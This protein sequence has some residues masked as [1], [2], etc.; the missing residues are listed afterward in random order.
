M[1]LT[2]NK[3]VLLENLTNVVKGTSIA[4][5]ENVVI[6]DTDENIV[7]KQN[8]EKAETEK[9][10]HQRREEEGES[11][12]EEKKEEKASRKRRED[13]DDKQCLQMIR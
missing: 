1:K 4:K 13:G 12:H 10:N 5:N 2:I 11:E 8:I 7:K 3:N 9:I 6:T